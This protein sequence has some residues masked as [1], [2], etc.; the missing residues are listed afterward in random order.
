MHTPHPAPEADVGPA[1]LP[2]QRG[3]QR[4]LRRWRHLPVCICIL[5]GAEQLELGCSVALCGQLLWQARIIRQKLLAL[6]PPAGGV[7]W[8]VCGSRRAPGGMPGG[9][10]AV[11]L[12][13]WDDKGGRCAAEQQQRHPQQQQQ[14][15]EEQQ[16]LRVG[17]GE[18]R[19]EVQ[20]VGARRSSIQQQT[21]AW[22]SQ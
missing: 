10:H 14:A 9:I 18:W 4:T 5:A 7:Q 13:F 2:R 6:P 16:A 20:A 17:K 11:A 12:D 22:T 21:Q 8:E 3:H 1:L 19:G 15:G